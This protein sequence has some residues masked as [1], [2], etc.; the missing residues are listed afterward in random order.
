VGGAVFKQVFRAF[1]IMAVFTLWVNAAMAADV[2]V[3]TAPAPISPAAPAPIG[4]MPAPIAAPAGIS[5]PEGAVGAPVTQGPTDSSAPASAPDDEDAVKKPK[6]IMVFGDSLSAGFGLPLEQSFPSQ[7]EARLKGANLNVRVINAGVS[8]D[9]TAAGLSR[10]NYALKQNPDY[11]ILELGGNDMLRAI[12]PVVTRENL[13]RMLEILKTYNRPV[14]LAGMRAFPNLG[15]AFEVAYARFY[16]DLATSYGIGYYPFFLDGVVGKPE[17]LQ[18][19]GIHPNAAGVGV[20]VEN[21]LPSV[22]DL[23]VA[24]SMADQAST[25]KGAAP[26]AATTTTPKTPTQK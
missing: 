24:K 11:I 9:T 15:P 1:I 12:D 26:A 25:A 19:D 20:I 8:G 18:D 21:I 22:A 16:Q 6:S 3:T 13:R 4:A 7:L 10:L 17:L 5:A 14:L 23:L 2:P